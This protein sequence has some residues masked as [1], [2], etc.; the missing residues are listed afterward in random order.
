MAG[1]F[2]FLHI[3]RTGG[4]AV[5]NLLASQFEESSIQ[6]VPHDIRASVSTA[7]YPIDPHSNLNH[8][9]QRFQFQ[10]HQ[11]V[12]GHWDWGIVDRIPGAK[13]V[14]TILR[15][16][17]ER[18]ISLWRYV[19][20]EESLYGGLS[21]QARKLGCLGWLT[22]HEALWANV[23]VKQ[24]VGVR[25]SQPREV[26]SSDVEIACERIRTIGYAGVTERLN[27]FVQHMIERQGWQGDL[28]HINATLHQTKSVSRDIQELVYEKAKC[29]VE[30]YKIAQYECERIL[31]SR[32]I[33]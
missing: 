2:I 22:R 21:I 24:L 20:Q 7:C 8:Q 5:R 32:P 15:N 17:A 25:W 6:P 16:P 12:M 14:M 23:M 27:E 1:T 10:G 31:Q 3:D 19:C 29:D 9:N 28:L 30:C 18:A 33:S 13:T 11:L 4:M 26:T